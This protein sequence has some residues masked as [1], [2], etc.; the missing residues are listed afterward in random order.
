MCPS[1]RHMRL[2][3]CRLAEPGASCRYPTCPTVLSCPGAPV[4]KN[5]TETCGKSRSRR[6]SAVCRAQLNPRVGFAARAE[7]ADENPMSA[8]RRSLCP[9]TRRETGPQAIETW[10]SRVPSRSHGHY[11]VRLRDAGVARTYQSVDAHRNPHRQALAW[12]ASKAAGRETKALG[13]D[14]RVI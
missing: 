5:M 2:S 14:L 8:G 4:G 1:G 9:P 13:M 11:V 12:G 6:R 7:M 10:G 3:S